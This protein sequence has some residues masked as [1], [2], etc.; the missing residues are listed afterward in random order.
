MAFERRE[1]KRGKVPFG[2]GTV[3][4][5]GVMIGVSDE[6]GAGWGTA[7]AT[8]WRGGAGRRGLDLTPHPPLSDV[9]SDVS[10]A[11]SF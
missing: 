7:A 1:G 3:E 9:V 4:G 8:Y 6:E 10:L 5:E 11:A 2:G